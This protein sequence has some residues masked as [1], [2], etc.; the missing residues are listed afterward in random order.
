MS[1]ELVEP[2]VVTPEPL[3]P[4]PAMGTIMIVTL[5]EKADEVM[6]HIK[7]VLNDVDWP[8]QMQYLG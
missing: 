8:L 3:P 6:D 1:D 4:A 2:D 5:D 7:A